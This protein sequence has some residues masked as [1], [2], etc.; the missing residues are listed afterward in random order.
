MSFSILWI[1]EIKSFA[2]LFLGDKKKEKTRI[3]HENRPLPYASQTFDY[4]DFRYYG[5]IANYDVTDPYG[6]SVLQQKD[7]C[8]D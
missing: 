8:R 2:V 1:F 5:D 3:S 7:R 6:K 4:F